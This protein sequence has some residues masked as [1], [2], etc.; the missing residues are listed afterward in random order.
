[1]DGERIALV[2][3]PLGEF[4]H[5][6]ISS[7]SH[8]EA[9]KTAASVREDQRSGSIPVSFV[10]PDQIP[11]GQPH[12]GKYQDANQDC[13]YQPGHVHSRS[14]GGRVTIAFQPSKKNILR[15]SNK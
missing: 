14:T 7:G 15:T 12:R 5:R 3:L 8:E 9:V 2:Q 11:R 6:R 1:M 10:V 13:S 4:G